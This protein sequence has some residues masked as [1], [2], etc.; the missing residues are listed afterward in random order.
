MTV[1]CIT[2][3][4]SVLC[5]YGWQRPEGWS[6]CAVYETCQRCCVWHPISVDTSNNAWFSL[7]LRQLHRR[8]S[9]CVRF[10]SVFWWIL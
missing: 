6:V 1:C 4:F 9:L 10:R 5:V 3:E 2:L 8:F 7:L